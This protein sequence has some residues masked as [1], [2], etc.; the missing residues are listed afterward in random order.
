MR[1]VE[2]LEAHWGARIPAF[3]R[4]VY[5]GQTAHR[6]GG[7]R[8]HAGLWRPVDL[9]STSGAVPCLVYL[10]AGDED[11]YEQ[12]LGERRPRFRTPSSWF[13]ELDYLAAHHRPDRGRGHSI[14]ARQLAR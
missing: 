7:F 5:V 12:A 3:E 2:A 13:E 4:S 1:F 6:G 8:R 11:F 9:G 14:P 10:G